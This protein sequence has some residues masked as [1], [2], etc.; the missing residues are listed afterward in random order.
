MDFRLRYQPCLAHLG[1]GL[2][3]Q[4]SRPILELF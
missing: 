1:D 3:N 4:I 2:E